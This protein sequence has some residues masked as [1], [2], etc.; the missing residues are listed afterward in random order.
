MGW[1][2]DP[3][4]M[5]KF[6]P[7]VSFDRFGLFAT[8]LHRYANETDQAV[9]HS[10]LKEQNA[11]SSDWRWAWQLVV[12]M[13]YTDCPL[14]SPL[15]SNSSRHVPRSVMANERNPL[16]PFRIALKF[17]ENS[18]LLVRLGNAAGLKFD[19]TMNE[20]EAYSH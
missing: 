8:G 16:D 3:K 5:L 19:L 17:V 14:Y 7:E 4:H 18:D 13:H 12:P 2:D 15:V 9:V 1:S 6:C 20:D 10:A 11:S